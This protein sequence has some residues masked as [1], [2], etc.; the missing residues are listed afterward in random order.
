MACSS[1]TNCIRRCMNISLWSLWIT[2][3]YYFTDFTEYSELEGTS[4]GSSSP[5]L[6]ECPLLLSWFTWI[7]INL[8]KAYLSHIAMLYDQGLAAL[9]IELDIK[10]TLISWSEDKRAS[11]CCCVRAVTFFSGA[12]Q[13]LWVSALDSVRVLIPECLKIS[14]TLKHSSLVALPEPVEE[15]C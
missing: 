9:C 7:S 1:H 13:E 14:V 15:S 12:G 11:H 5:T 6:S 4:Q 2:L 3:P 8:L 10:L